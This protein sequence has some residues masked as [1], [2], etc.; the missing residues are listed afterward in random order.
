MLET[1]KSL[2]NLLVM[3]QRFLSTE[4]KT[5]SDA[6]TTTATTTAKE[7]AA[8]V[9]KDIPKAPKAPKPTEAPKPAGSPKPPKKVFFFELL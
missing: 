1:V 9:T 3:K 6:S 4:A 2:A 7:A 8:K 5:T